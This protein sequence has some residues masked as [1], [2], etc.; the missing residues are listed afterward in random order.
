MSETI[1]LLVLG[2][3]LTALGIFNIRGNIA[4]VHW[5]NRMKVTEKNRRAYGKSIGTGTAIIGGSLAA[6]GILQLLAGEAHGAYIV[7]AG[8]VAGLSFMLYAQF[9]YNRGIF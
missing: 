5:Y 3:L 2:L 9:K 7:L 1:S 8:V 4:S 6:A